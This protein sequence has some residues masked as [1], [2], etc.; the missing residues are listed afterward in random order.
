M[1]K[2]TKWW[3]TTR[4][5][6]TQVIP[7]S[8][9][10]AADKKCYFYGY[11]FNLSQYFLEVHLLERHVKDTPIF[12]EGFGFNFT[13]SQIQTW[14]GWVGGANPTSALCCPLNFMH[15]W[16]LARL[17]AINYECARTCFFLS[18]AVLG[19]FVFG[20]SCRLIW[21]RSVDIKMSSC[22]PETPSANWMDISLRDSKITKHD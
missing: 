20:C 18:S 13:S 19:V 3:R 2:W 10:I 14:D 8:L 5:T 6:T 16:I 15:S 4:R 22:W 11:S 9:P 21:L 7:W 1:R 12:K 17:E